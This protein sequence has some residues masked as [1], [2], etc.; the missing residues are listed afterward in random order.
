MY[1]LKHSRDQSQVLLYL[2]KCRRGRSVQNR[3]LAFL[4]LSSLP[5]CHVMHLLNSMIQNRAFLG[6][7]NNT[8]LFFRSS[9]RL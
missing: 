9:D 2:G 7:L 5:L 4:F 1:E 3:H 8:M 6:A